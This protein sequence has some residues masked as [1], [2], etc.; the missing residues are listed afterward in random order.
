MGHPG[1]NAA[2]WLIKQGFGAINGVKISPDQRSIVSTGS[3][4]AIFI[5]HMPKS[6]LASK[7]DNDMPERAASQN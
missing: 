1:E 6:V 3:E 7:A 5:W 4:G 2:R